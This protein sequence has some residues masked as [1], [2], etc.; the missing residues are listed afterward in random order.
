MD[1]DTEAMDTEV[2]GPSTPTPS[3]DEGPATPTPSDGE[4]APTPTD[5][6]AAPRPTSVYDGFSDEEAAKWARVDRMVGQR[7]GDDAELPLSSARSAAR[8]ASVYDGFS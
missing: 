5:L 8:P 7:A 6:D 1:T 2:E 4:R 3:D